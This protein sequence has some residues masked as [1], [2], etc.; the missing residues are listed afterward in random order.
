MANVQTA[1]SRQANDRSYRQC[2]YHKT[3]TGL[4]GRKWKAVSSMLKKELIE[5]L[6]HWGVASFTV[7]RRQKGMTKRAFEQIHLERL[8]FAIDPRTKSKTSPSRDELYAVVQLVSHKRPEFIRTKADVFFCKISTADTSNH[9]NDSTITIRS[10]PL[11]TKD[12]WFNQQS[13]CGVES[14]AM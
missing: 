5:L 11:R 12:I 10:L 3:K 6:C 8:T 13:S 7:S 1:L 14:R 2:C 9:T 4:N